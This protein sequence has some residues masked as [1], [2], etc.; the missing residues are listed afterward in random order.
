MCKSSRYPTTRVSGSTITDDSKTPELLCDQT[1]G[2]CLFLEKSVPVDSIDHPEAGEGENANSALLDTRSALGLFGSLERL[3]SADCTA[4]IGMAALSASSSVREATDLLAADVGLSRARARSAIASG[5]N[6]PR[7]T[8]SN[9]V[10]GAIAGAHVGQS[11][12]Q[13]LR[14]CFDFDVAPHSVNAA[15]VTIGKVISAKRRNGLSR[16]ANAAVRSEDL[17]TILV[18]AGLLST[19]RISPDYISLLRNALSDAD[20]NEPTRHSIVMRN[21][22]VMAAYAIS[23]L[24]K[25]GLNLGAEQLKLGPPLWRFRAAPWILPV[26][27]PGTPGAVAKLLSTA[28]ALN[29]NFVLPGCSPFDS[30][31]TAEDVELARALAITAEHSMTKMVDRPAWFAGELP[32][33]PQVLL[34][35]DDSCAYAWVGRNGRGMLVCFDTTYF[36]PSVVD[37]PG[38]AYAIACAIGWYIDLTVALKTRPKSTSRYVRAGGTKSVWCY[39]PTSG[40]HQD[41]WEIAGG[42]RNPPRPH[43]VSPFVRRLPAGQHPNPQHVAEAPARIRK[44]MKPGYTWVHGHPRGAGES[45]DWVNRL[46]KESALAGI[47]GSIGYRNWSS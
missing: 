27:E 11:A 28:R 17:L 41:I 13:A 20:F 46:S 12:V 23:A 39:K 35:E 1:L 34:I 5:G 10:I 9:D 43:R 15:G 16:V 6:L 31:G 2:P 40:W 19:L 30:P 45:V 7:V 29:L 21:R 18:A 47:L 14:R 8:G 24:D 42:N 44:R 26:V 25:S 37:E 22:V 36:Y 3:S 32:G 4:L 33:D 38:V